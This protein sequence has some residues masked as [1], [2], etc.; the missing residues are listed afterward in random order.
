MNKRMVFIHFL[1]L[2]VRIRWRQTLCS[3]N[4]RCLIHFLFSLLLFQLN[5]LPRHWSWGYCGIRLLTLMLIYIWHCF[6]FF[7]LQELLVMIKLSQKDSVLGVLLQVIGI[8]PHAYFQ[9]D[10]ALE[11]NGSSV[12]KFVEVLL[13][14]VLEVVSMR[15]LLDTIMSGTQ[16][17]LG[18]GPCQI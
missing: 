5:L 4:L 16:Y 14:G 9:S 12:L 7:E 3:L 10:I 13:R 11:I 6:A 8:V 1:L 18:Q 15:V 2:L 17:S